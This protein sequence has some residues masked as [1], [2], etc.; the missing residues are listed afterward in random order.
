[1]VAEQWGSV[2]LVQK[3]VAMSTKSPLS[4]VQYTEPVSMERLHN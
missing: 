3:E 2:L 1:M 4:T